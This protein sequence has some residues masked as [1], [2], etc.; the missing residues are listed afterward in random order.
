M[1]TIRCSFV[2]SGA[3]CMLDASGEKVRMDSNHGKTVEDQ[4]QLPSKSLAMIAIQR[5]EPA[6]VMRRQRMT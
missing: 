3:S 1:L 2:R 6:A 5:A 4:P